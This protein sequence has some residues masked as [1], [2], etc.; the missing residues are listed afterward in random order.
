MET[1]VESTPKIGMV[2]DSVEDVWKFR[3]EYGGK[4]RFNV[5]RHYENKNK[6]GEVTSRRFVCAKE[7]HRGI[8]KG[9]NLGKRDRAETRT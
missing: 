6:S 5:R 2:F 7:G 1:S 8:G 4:M 9:D 3:K